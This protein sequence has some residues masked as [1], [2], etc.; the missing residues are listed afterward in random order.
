MKLIRVGWQRELEII[1]ERV[2]Q[3]LFLERGSEEEAGRKERRLPVRLEEQMDT[4]SNKMS[5]NQIRSSMFWMKGMY[6]R[7]CW[8]VQRIP[9][10]AKEEETMAGCKCFI[11]PSIISVP[12]AIK[13]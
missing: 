7:G 2:S 3:Q 11:A 9:P 4:Q 10:K 8:T 6:N 5:P 13:D 1:K 12:E